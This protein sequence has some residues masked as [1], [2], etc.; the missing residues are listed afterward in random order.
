[1]KKRSLLIGIS[2]GIA[3]YKIIELIRLFKKNNIDIW[4]VSTKNALKFITPLTLRTITGNPHF[5]DMFSEENIYSMPHI[6]LATI[7]DIMLIAPATANII[8][9]ISNGIA[10]DLLSTLA[11][12][13]RGKIFI[14]PAMNNYMYLNPIVQENIAHIK[15]FD[16]YS[17]IEPEKGSLACGEE[18][19]GR[20]AEINKI[21]EIIMNE[22]KK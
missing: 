12:S 5:Y 18:G 10:D 11:L 17:I 1:M 2:G 21:F 14:A 4:T 16:K 15:K 22:F 20:L 13:F 7:A 8:G 6:S 3:A 9:K 19:V